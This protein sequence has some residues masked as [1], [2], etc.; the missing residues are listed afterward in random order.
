MNPHY[1]RSRS[2]AFV[3][4]VAVTWQLTVSVPTTIAG[5]EVDVIDAAA[6][7]A[8]YGLPSDPALV[9]A[10]IQSGA[11]V[12]TDK[13]GI[14]LTAAEEAA[15]D[16]PGRMRF[17][18]EL[19]E[20]LLPY[21][22]ALPTYGGAYIDPAAG[23]RIVV[24]LTKADAAV[25]TRIRELAPQDNRGV[26]V[27][28]VTHSFRALQDAAN[29]APATWEDVGTTALLAVG[30]DEKRNALVVRVAAEDVSQATDD[31][32]VVERRLGVPILILEGSV[33]KA[34]ACNTRPIAIAPCE[35]EF[36]SRTTS[37]AADS[38]AQWAST[39]S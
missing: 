32:A 7:R 10:I 37:V 16:L 5:T 15:L 14:V 11:D 38:S 23:G 39:L 20:S 3:A 4:I 12:G 21:A 8:V 6:E 18:D 34:L 17:V 13:W 1:L 33:E 2:L 19:S 29:K 35:L 36:C 28:V 9:E 27:K 31:A 22:A 26:E 25:T 30:A 24:H